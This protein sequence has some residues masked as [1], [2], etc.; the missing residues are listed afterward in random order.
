MRKYLDMSDAA[1]DTP[2]KRFSGTFSTFSSLSIVHRI[3][4]CPLPLQ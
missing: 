1:S 3:R 4:L 2:R